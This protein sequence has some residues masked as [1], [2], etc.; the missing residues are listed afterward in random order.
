MSDLQT[1]VKLK[2][3]PA[4]SVYRLSTSWQSCC[5]EDCTG[6]GMLLVN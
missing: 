4:K 1:P 2:H 3:V 5:P 6:A